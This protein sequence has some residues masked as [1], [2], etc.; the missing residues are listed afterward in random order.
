VCV[1]KTKIVGGGMI[2]GKSAVR[3][4]GQSSD[5]KIKARRTI[6]SLIIAIWGEFQ[7]SRLRSE[8][9]KDMNCN[10][11]DLCIALATPLIRQGTNVTNTSEHESMPDSRNPGFVHTQPGNRPN[12]SG[13][14]EE[15]I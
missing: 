11:V 14:E 1:N 2:L 13:D 9:G 12:G 4:A 5:C 10:P 3:R 7:D 6:L 8:L 15:S